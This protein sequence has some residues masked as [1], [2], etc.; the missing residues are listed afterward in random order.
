MKSRIIVFPGKM[1]SVFF[2]NEIDYIISQ[3]DNVYIFSYKGAISQY[4][5]IAVEKNIQYKVVSDIS[6][7]SI[8][9]LIAEVLIHKNKDIYY[10]IHKAWK[11]NG[12]LIIKLKR[13]GY[14]LFY[15]KIGRAHV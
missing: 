6:W 1:D 5:Q 9:H 15:V 8:F 11:Q 4:N 2:L 3:F 14:L 10:E 12:N 13:I 7:Y